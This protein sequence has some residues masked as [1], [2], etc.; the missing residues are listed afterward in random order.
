MLTLDGERQPDCSRSAVPSPWEAARARGAAFRAVGN[1][2]GWSIE[3][4]SGD[5]PALR[6]ELD[7]G[8]RSIEVA[9]AAATADGWRGAAPD[10]TQVVLE[11]RREECRDPM[12]GHAFPASARLR[13]GDSTWRGCGRFLLE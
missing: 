10:G 13:V 7:F 3:V 9:S 12:S 4:G 6:A 11:I 2:P 1:E 5:A 8:A